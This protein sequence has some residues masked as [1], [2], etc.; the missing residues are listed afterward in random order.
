MSIQYEIEQV[1]DENKPYYPTVSSVK[2]VLSK[3]DHFPYTRFYNGDYRSPKVIFFDREAG[4]SKISPRCYRDIYT[5]T[6]DV[7]PDYCFQAPASV[8]YPCHRDNM[9]QAKCKYYKGKSNYCPKSVC[10]LK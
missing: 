6:P 4:Y 3:V 9:E 1:Q 10:S 5:D 8:V 7:I 2:R